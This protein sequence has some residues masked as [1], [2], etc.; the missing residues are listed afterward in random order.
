MASLLS[1]LGVALVDGNGVDQVFKRGQVF[2]NL[3]YRTAVLRDDDVKP[4]PELEDEFKKNGG[5]VTCW[6]EGRTLEDDLF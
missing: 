4:T 3:G 6:R 5:K 1:A 2:R